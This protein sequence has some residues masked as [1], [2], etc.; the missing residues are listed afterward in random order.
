MSKHTWDFGGAAPAE[1]RCGRCGAVLSQADA[2]TRIAELER[3]IE[4]Y[5][6]M[7]LNDSFKIDRLEAEN[8]A[9][10]DALYHSGYDPE[11]CIDCGGPPH[12]E[13][14]R[15]WKLRHLFPTWFEE[16]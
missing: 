7:A 14:C 11:D 10:V 5:D 9:L 12:N 2:P 4:T 15:F 6:G 3:D 1:Y 16:E 8:A 13:Q